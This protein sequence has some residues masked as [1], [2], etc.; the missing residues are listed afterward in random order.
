MKS[1]ISRAVK[2]QKRIEE[3][4]SC[5]DDENV[6][7]RLFGTKAFMNCTHKIA[8]WMSAA[9]L[10]THTDN[11]GNVRGKL[12]S[13]TPNAKTF[14]IGSQYNNDKSEGKFDGPL[15]I[16][17]GL[18]V[19]QN[20]IENNISLDFHLEI[21][22]FSHKEDTRFNT[23]YLGSKTLAGKFNTTLLL[24]KKDENGHTLGEALTAMKLDVSQ[25][26]NEK[27]NEKDWLGYLEI[28]TE[29]GMI[30]HNKK[31]PV[32][33]VVTLAGQMRVEINFT[34]KPG[35]AGIVPM[36]VRVDALCAAAQFIIEAEEY[37]TPERRNLVAT[38]GKIMVKNAARNVIPHNVSCTLDIR[39]ADT[40]R[41][42][43]AYESLNTI[44]ERICHKREVYFEWKLVHETNPVQCDKKL[45][46]MLD[47][48]ISNMKLDILDMVSGAGHDAAIIS[49]VAPVAMLFIKY[50]KSNN[51]NALGNV[52]TK[53]IASALEVSDTFLQLL[54]LSEKTRVKL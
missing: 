44:C 33:A 49:Q 23:S 17:A 25:L 40:V 35:H 34:G 53:D 2:I 45:T 11:I 5:S 1:Y 16:L 26:R 21:V 43:K 51:F 22:A 4:A 48:A 24:D 30:L 19:A 38:V 29:Q 28:H 9:G 31:I 37:A 50:N 13:Q 15:S 12:L 27:I 14:V 41:L 8:N 10:Q 3:M 52:E 54:N 36:N 39:S 47:Q 7:S 6:L 42:S 32:C 46:G 20:I 18:D